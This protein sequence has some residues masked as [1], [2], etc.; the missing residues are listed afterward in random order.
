MYL[1]LNSEALIMSM[2]E[3]KSL[4]PALPRVDEM[5]TLTGKLIL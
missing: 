2:M 1:R 5:K 3:T 4:E